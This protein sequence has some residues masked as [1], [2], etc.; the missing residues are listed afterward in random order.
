M[1]RPRLA[2]META[3]WCPDDR[4]T[5]IGAMF[6]ILTQLENEDP[7]SF[8]YS[9]SRLCTNRVPRSSGAALVE[10]DPR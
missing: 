10:R 4:I 1:S 7:N 2:V 9:S 8:L 3:S 5:S 6:W